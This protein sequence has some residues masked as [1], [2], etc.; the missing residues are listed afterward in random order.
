MV[1][2]YHHHH[3]PWQPSSWL[4]F[5]GAS[6]LWKRCCSILRRTLPVD[7]EETN[8]KALNPIS[9]VT[10]RTFWILSLLSSKGPKNH[11]RWMNG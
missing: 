8:V 2:T 6:G 3:H 11:F 4:S 10:S 9:S 5:W 1:T 7:E